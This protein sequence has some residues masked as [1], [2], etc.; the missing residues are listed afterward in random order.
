MSRDLQRRIAA[1]ADEVRHHL[2]LAAYHERNGNF[3]AAADRRHS[4]DWSANTALFLAQS[5]GRD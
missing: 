3:A 1:L 4:A 5:P 2:E